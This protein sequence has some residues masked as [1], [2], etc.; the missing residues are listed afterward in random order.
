MELPPGENNLGGRLRM[1]RRRQLETSLFA[2]IRKEARRRL[3]CCRVSPGGVHGSGSS[4]RK[5]RS[6]AGTRDGDEGA[7]G[8]GDG[9]RDRSRCRLCG[10]R[11]EEEGA[12]GEGGGDGGDHVLNEAAAGEK[13]RCETS[14]ASQLDWM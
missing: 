9:V 3:R 2:A 11:V 12:G 4:V 13:S 8:G 6:S 7:E 5:S 1:R 14:G 10:A